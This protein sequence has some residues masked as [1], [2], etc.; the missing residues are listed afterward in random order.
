MGIYFE[1]RTK[2]LQSF[3]LFFETSAQG[4]WKKKIVIKKL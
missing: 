4:T 2:Y 3:F 1:N